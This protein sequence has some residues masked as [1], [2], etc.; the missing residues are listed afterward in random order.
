MLK[1]TFKT[2]ITGIILFIIL[3]GTFVMAGYK[4]AKI[5]YTISGSIGVGGVIMNG[6]PGNPVTNENGYYTATVE[7]G[8]KGTVTPQKEGYTFEPANKAYEKV[9]GNQDNQSY[10]ATLITFTVKGSAGQSG[11]VMNGLPGAPITDEK[12]NYTATVNYGFTGTVSPTKEGYIFGPANKIYEPVKANEVSQD[13]IAKL[14]TFTITGTTGMDGVVMNG[15][16]GNPVTKDGGKYSA[17]VD[18]GFSGAATPSK[19]GYTF[20][21]AN[22]IYAK[23]AGDQANQSYAGTLIT[24][25][26]AGST[27]QSGV[28][29]N[30]L[31]G[32]PVTN[33]KG[34]YTATVDY[35]WK[36]I[37]TPT[38]E[39]YIFG[40][41]NK[42][43]ESVKANQ[44]SQ[45][46]SAKLKTFTIS[47]STGMDGIVMNGLPGNPVTKDGGKYSATVDYG[48]SGTVMP[49][50][51]G[52]TFEPANRIYAKA[53][54]DQANQSYAGTLITLIISGSTG[55]SGVVMSGLPGNPV[56]NDK[57]NYTATVNYGFAGTI[58]P[59]KEG[60]I[61]DPANKIY[62]PVK[63]NQ[64][65]QDY[66][67]K[68][69]TFAISGTTG[70]DGVVMN[71]L[72]GNPVTSG[73]GLYTATV[74]Y[75]FS[76]TIT[77]A[78]EGYTFEPANRIYAKTAGDQAN[79]GYT[80][81]L[82]TLTISGIVNINNEPIEGVL[83]QADNG[84]G[85][86][87][88]DA[89]GRY[90]LKVNYGWTGAVTPTKEGYMF[91]PA[92]KAY[93]N[94][95]TNIKE[96]E[97][98]KDTEPK[99]AEQQPAAPESPV[100][101]E[102]AVKEINQSTE[103]AAQEASASTKAVE[104]EIIEPAAEAAKPAE[105][106]QP[107]ETAAP[108]AEAAAIKSTNQTQNP[109]AE[110]QP[111]TPLVSN[112]FIDTDIRQV[113]QDI[114]SQTGFI[115]IPDQTVAG[116]I[117]CE[118]K[119]VPLDK[120][121]EIVLAGTGY[122]VRKTPDYYLVSSPEPKEVTFPTS[123]KTKY[124]KMSYVG[125]EDA[126]KL[127]SSA[128][129][130]YVQAD[131]AS[132]TV[133]ITAPPVLIDRI[134]S[135]LE[136]ID[137]PPRH[138]MLNARIVV[139]NRQD[140]LNLGIEWSWPKISAG[141]F[142]NSL[143]HENGAAGGKWPWGVQIGYTTG[144]SFTNSLELTLNL[145]EQNGDAT[146]MSTPQILAQD[147]KKAEIKV[148][149][150]E[151]YSLLPK[152]TGSV[153]YYYTS[154]LQ[155]IEYGTVLNII[156][157]I[158][159]EGDITLDLA[160][161]VSDIVMRSTDNYPIVT[162]RVVNNTMRITDGGTVSVAGLKKT[163]N[164]TVNK[165]TPGLSKLPGVGGLFNNKRVEGTSQEIAVF[166]TAHLIPESAVPKTA[167]SKEQNKEQKRPSSSKQ[168][169]AN[170]FTKEIQKSLATTDSN[171]TN[172]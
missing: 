26:I 118:L 75:G 159:R 90:S 120:A 58:T 50:K 143:Q 122:V 43:Y 30:G 150:E 76:S 167:S 81:T 125:S 95:T 86:G 79:Q 88:T 46:Y 28:V 130:K 11:V 42:I 61:F 141:I 17:T 69:M 171:G 22:R 32:N 154:E 2:L 97:T 65:S 64:A 56:T 18:Y 33:D 13:Y 169:T 161:E 27:G 73:G 89:N 124:I 84:G 148:T 36:G 48:F 40:P 55:Q 80:G 71:G 85:S 54:G 29:M 123:S 140:L 104:P 7:Y 129:K 49:T 111:K 72:P 24:L 77:P 20:E 31:P 87:I 9:T 34:D 155:K 70:M 99:T 133:V 25:T 38:K 151:Y 37:I 135:D 91:D 47:G 127:L 116:L 113:L 157:H 137:I 163:E 168:Q 156:P 142:S 5:T 52:Y 101:T 145:L 114:S 41:A 82:I 134:E 92:N 66:I 144:Q 131:A 132:G 115:I 102:A 170:D 160:I 23:T 60:Y 78:K 112:V 146:I 158:G 100:S 6:L 51:E 19:E 15:L 16:P 121:L 126:V 83:M 117:S 153:P 35:G 98:E 128:F 14:M 108:K 149:T 53:T 12:G 4:A 103:T 74:D 96:D 1:N 21:P 63:A 147:G 107:V 59:T 44:V 152:T 105:A 162:R 164:Y 62:E 57:G 8:W 110:V 93:T 94:V 119:E 39:G 172:K 138:V 109:P 166:V 67:A 68:L 139:M 3:P 45:D 136:L 106:N 10:A 165:S